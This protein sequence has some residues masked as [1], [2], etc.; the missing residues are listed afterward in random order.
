MGRTILLLVTLAMVLAAGWVVPR[1]SGRGPEAV[2][3][4]KGMALTQAILRDQRGQPRH[5]RALML[6]H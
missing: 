5:W 1:S 3:D 4:S 2:P 6:Q